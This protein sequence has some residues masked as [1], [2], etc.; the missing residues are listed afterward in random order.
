MIPTETPTNRVKSLC[1]AVHT[2]ELGGGQFVGFQPGSKPGPQHYV[3]L[4]NHPL[5]QGTFGLPVAELTKEAL[6]RKI[7]PKPFVQNRDSLSA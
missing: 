4:F 1:W 2:V 6:A 5:S 3:V 7:R